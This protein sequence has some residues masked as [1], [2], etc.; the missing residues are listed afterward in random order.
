MRQVAFSTALAGLLAGAFAC[1][2]VGLG[3]GQG[4]VG[5]RVDFPAPAFQ[6]QVIPATTARIEVVVSGEGMTSP[7]T[8][9]LTKSSPSL[10]VSVP[11]G[12]KQ[13]Q[14][15]A[16][17]ATGKVVADGSAAVTVIARSK[18][19][20]RV[21]LAPT[22]EASPSAS[23]SGPAVDASGNPVSPPPD[24]QT[25]PPPSPTPTTSP[26]PVPTTSPTAVPTATT[27]QA[28]SGGGG[29]GALATP[30]PTPVATVSAQIIVIP[31]NAGPGVRDL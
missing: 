8:S 28:P 6:V 17:D 4:E 25:S 7:L 15:R 24:V 2:P 26:T 9:T 29:G 13:V 3:Q 14:A 30:T 11:A 16:F 21:T 27:T 31:P 19:Q 20:A 10:V 23:P 18:V 12:S 5:L 22:P 1:Q